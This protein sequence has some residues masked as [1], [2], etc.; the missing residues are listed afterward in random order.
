MF[1]C[2]DMESK[3]SKYD[4]KAVLQKG[5]KK[6]IVF[7]VQKQPFIISSLFKNLPDIYDRKSW[8]F[9]LRSH[10]QINYLKRKCYA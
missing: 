2:N 7:F 5:V 6:K 3:R 10:I 1:E 8:L 4:I 9:S